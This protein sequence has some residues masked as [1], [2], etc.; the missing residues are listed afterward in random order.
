MFFLGK[1]THIPASQPAQRLPG[2]LAPQRA[3][4][5]AENSPEFGRI[6]RH[7]EVNT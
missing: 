7:F 6:P 2:T 5:R 3:I 1:N 4:F